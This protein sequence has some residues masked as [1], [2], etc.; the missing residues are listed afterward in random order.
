MASPSRVVIC[1]LR[2]NRQT[3]FPSKSRWTSSSDSWCG[4][5]APLA[6][7]T[8]PP[9]STRA[10]P[11]AELLKPSQRLTTVPFMSITSTACVCSGDSTV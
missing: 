5:R 9:G 1:S 4:G 7:M 10:G 2:E 3:T 6:A 8:T 11:P